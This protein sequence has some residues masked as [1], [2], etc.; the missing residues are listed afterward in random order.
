MLYFIH[1]NAVEA[2]PPPGRYNLQ[3]LFCLSK[4][5]SMIV[6]KTIKFGRDL[7]SKNISYLNIIIHVFHQKVLSKVFSLVD[8]LLPPPCLSPHHAL[9]R[10]YSIEVITAIP[11]TRQYGDIQ[12]TKDLSW[13]TI[14]FHHYL[15]IVLIVM[16]RYNTA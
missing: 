12:K 2:L 4:K 8:R 16:Y 3:L 9:V 1:E 15:L 5:T 13:N 14:A 10:G 11:I 7:I 6:V